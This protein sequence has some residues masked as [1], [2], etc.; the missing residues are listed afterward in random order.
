MWT[1]VVLSLAFVGVEMNETGRQ[2]GADVVDTSGS[3][4]SDAAP[5][6]DVT[7]S[8]VDTDCCTHRTAHHKGSRSGS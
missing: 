8:P 3:A 1:I 7:A 2:N 6:S 5:L 4:K